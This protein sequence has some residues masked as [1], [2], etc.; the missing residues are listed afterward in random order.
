MCPLSPVFS[1][2]I[3]AS[4]EGN[5]HP[6][7]RVNIFSRRTFKR[8]KLARRAREEDD[9]FRDPEGVGPPS[10]E[11]PTWEDTPGKDN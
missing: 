8:G 5:F 11:L 1:V 3:H 4:N 2:D 6:P 10:L 7:P 9:G